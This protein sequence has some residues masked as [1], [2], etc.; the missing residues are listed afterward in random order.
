MSNK[1]KDIDTKNRTH[2]FSN[3]MINKRNLDSKKVRI[4]E[5][6]YKNFFIYFTEYVTVKNLTCAKANSVNPLYIIIDKTNRYIEESN[7]N[8]YS[9]LVPTYESKDPLKNYEELFR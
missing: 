1:F 2:Y 9:T 3:D 7:Q 5:N 6:W 4:D 8:K